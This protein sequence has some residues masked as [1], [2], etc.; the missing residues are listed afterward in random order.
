MLQALLHAKKQRFGRSSEATQIPGQMSLFE[1]NEELAK[2]LEADEE[3]IV[4]PSHKRT[5][6]KTGVRKEMLASL[7]K[8]ITEYVINEEDTCHKCGTE[9]SFSF[10]TQKR[11][12][13]TFLFITV[14][15]LFFSKF[16]NRLLL[17]VPH[18]EH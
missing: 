5:P 12:L 11:Q 3:K 9:G 17:F 14:L 16:V 10:L 2:A 15:T 7:P 1:T 18:Q 6:R 13:Q 8:E 4:V